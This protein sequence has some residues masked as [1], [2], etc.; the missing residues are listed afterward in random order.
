MDFIT[1]LPKSNDREFILVVVDRLSKYGHFLVLSHPFTAL[2]V[3][4]VYLDNIFKLHGQPKSIVN[5]KDAVF[6]S[7]FWKHQFMV[8]GTQF[9]NV[10]CLS[11]GYDG[12]TRLLID[13]FRHIQS[14][15][16]LIKAKIGVLGY[17]QQ[18]GG[19]IL[20]LKLLLA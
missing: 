14:V 17:H 11:S 18:N 10:I 7:D 8:H 9:F 16:A 12:Q 19:I 13:V 5:D 2:Q 20:I 4:R 3:A 6:L 1:G 15:C